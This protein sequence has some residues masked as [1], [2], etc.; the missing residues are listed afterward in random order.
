MQCYKVIT[1][2]NSSDCL[3]INSADDSTSVDKMIL[4][5]SPYRSFLH[6]FRLHRQYYAID[7]IRAKTYGFKSHFFN[8][9]SFSPDMS[10]VKFSSYFLN[11]NISQIF[12]LTFLK[13]AQLI[14]CNKCR[15]IGN[16][17]SNCAYR[18]LV[19]G[20]YNGGNLAKFKA[21]I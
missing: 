21:G 19:R 5:D 17:S 12:N 3:L 20:V 8:K 14:T 4:G 6:V 10:L 13:V 7:R 11:K 9:C 16:K 18:Y 15:V 1:N 2:K